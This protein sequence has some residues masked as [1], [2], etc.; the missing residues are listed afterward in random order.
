MW[1]F[2]TYVIV[3]IVYDI[4]LLVY[5]IIYFK[6][7]ELTLA[8]M[9]ENIFSQYYQMVNGTLAVSYFIPNPLFL[10]LWFLH[11]YGPNYLQLLLTNQRIYS[12]FMM[13]YLIKHIAQIIFGFPLWVRGMIGWV[14]TIITMLPLT[15]CVQ[16]ICRMSFIIMVM[17]AQLS[18]FASFNELSGHMWL[19]SSIRTLAGWDAC[20]NNEFFFDVDHTYEWIEIT[21]KLHYWLI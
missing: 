13:Y 9:N 18:F 2:I 10:I 4:I 3:K 5:V 11:V 12:V 17:T 19:V 16:R 6:N 14:V 7:H 1:F 21:V 20:Y 15:C 8:S